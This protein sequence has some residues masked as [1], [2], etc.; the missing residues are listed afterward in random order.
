MKRLL[1]CDLDNTLYDWVGYFVEAFYAMTDEVVRITGCDRETL[2]D[3]FRDVHRQ[4][5]DAEHPFALFET[6]IVK[7]L[8]PNKSFA[9]ISAAIDPAMHAFNKAKQHRLTLYPTV[10]STL[11]QLRGQNV[12]LVAHTESKLY[13]V[14]DRLSRLDLTRYF[15]HIYCRERSVSNHPGIKPAS[16]YLSHFPMKR[17]IELSH[18]QRKPNEDVLLEIC[19]REGVDPRDAAYV[20]DSIV[21]D[22]MMAK[23]ADVTAIWAKYGTRHDQDVYDRLVRVSHWTPE[24]VARE[25]L[26]SRQAADIKPD[27][28]L[29]HQFS[30]VLSAIAAEPVH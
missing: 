4:H 27:F 8:F 26:L 9:E 20:G 7:Q 6:R 23:R 29:E 16:E 18:H 25:R 3:D 10:R 19:E 11:D 14:V 21:R 15:S 17:V 24:D 22:M 12:V 5:H 30:D 13:A 1:I 2:L 28:T